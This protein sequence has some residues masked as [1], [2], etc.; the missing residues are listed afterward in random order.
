MSN[1]SQTTVFGVDQRIVALGFA[2]M[3]DAMGNSFLI[4]VLPL[5][6]ASNYVHGTFFGFTESMITGLVI[7]LFGLVSSFFQPITGIVSDKYGKRTIFVIA[8]LAIFTLANIS[9]SFA[10]TYWTMLII[11]SVQGLAAAL[12]I[13]TSVALVSEVGLPVN[14]G[15]NM[16]IYN[17]FR[18]VGLPMP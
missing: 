4:V 10:D 2:R 12:T 17:S 6:I 3:A 1:Q 13:T 15:R 14:R 7:G 5:Y 18:L 11:R 16:G 9:Y 8:G